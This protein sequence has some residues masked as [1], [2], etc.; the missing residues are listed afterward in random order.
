V[1]IWEEP[2]EASRDHRSK[3]ATDAK[4][5]EVGGDARRRRDHAARERRRRKPAT[6]PRA[7]I[8]AAPARAVHWCGYWISSVA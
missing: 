2:I 3:S 8:A 1:F 5:F 7:S 4:Q 6:R